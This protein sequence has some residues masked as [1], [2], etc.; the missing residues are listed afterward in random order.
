MTIRWITEAQVKAA[1]KKS[2]RAALAMSLRHW[3]Q[4]AAAGK[5][6]LSDALAAKLTELWPEWCSLCVRGRSQGV[7]RCRGCPLSNAGGCGPDS[8]FG[9]AADA[10]CEWEERPTSLPHW[11]IWRA[12]ARAMRDLL[13]KLYDEGKK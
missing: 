11:A 1:A 10:V 12:A 9:N 2:D 13:Q 7:C 6:Q 8:I 3:K 5:K 4:L